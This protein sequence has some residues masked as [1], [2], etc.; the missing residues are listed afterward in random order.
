MAKENSSKMEREPTIW[1]NL[2]A[3]DTSEKGLMSKIYKESH[4]STPGRQAIQLKIGKGP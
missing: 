4:E 1:Q 3:T 2:F